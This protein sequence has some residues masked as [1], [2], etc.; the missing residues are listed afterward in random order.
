MLVASCRLSHGLPPWCQKPAFAPGSSNTVERVKAI[1][2]EIHLQKHNDHPFLN[3]STVFFM[4]FSPE[5]R[6][7]F[8]Y[9]VQCAS[10]D[11]LFNFPCEWNLHLLAINKIS[12]NINEFGFVTLALTE[13]R[14]W[15]HNT[16][17]QIELNLF[18]RVG[19]CLKT[20]KS[21]A[22]KKIKPREKR[23]ML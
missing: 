9:P 2:W 5:K 14:R 20:L 16:W 3:P 7:F 18:R 12:R 11:Q 8:L 10:L 17:I 21:T 23:G 4:M 1:I 6:E 15:S 13:G 19:R 22:L